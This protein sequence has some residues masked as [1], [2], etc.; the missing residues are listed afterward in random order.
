MTF[1]IPST[2]ASKDPGSLSTPSGG[3]ASAA[4]NGAAAPQKAFGEVM[5]QAFGGKAAAVTGVGK[6]AQKAGD[7]EDGEAAGTELPVDGTL[8]SQDAT[9]LSLLPPWMQ[10][11]PSHLAVEQV[12][13]ESG[14]QVITANTPAPDDASLMA[15]AQAQGLDVNAIAMLLH[16]QPPAAQTVLSTPSGWAQIGTVTQAGGVSATAGMTLPGGLEGV[17]A[18][19][20]A[21]ATATATG[22]G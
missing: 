12:H 5:A 8:A 20:T 9:D 4:G 1:D 13:P 2:S 18:P 21:T 6:S 16:K 19:G 17:A 15:F 22:D 11:L 14:L 7:Q 3:T 10:A